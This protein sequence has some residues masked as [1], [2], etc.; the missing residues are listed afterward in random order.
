MAGSN[1]HI[2]SF[3]NARTFFREAEAEF[4]A[5]QRRNACL[6]AH[7]A[8]SA[9][10]YYLGTM[11]AEYDALLDEPIAARM[12]RDVDLAETVLQRIADKAKR[13]VKAI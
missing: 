12:K 4:V 8:W 6:R 7:H 5:S 11:R 10:E 9:M 3:D 1:W 13:C 2:R